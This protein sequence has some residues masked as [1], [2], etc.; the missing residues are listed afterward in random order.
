MVN[1]RLIN[2][3]RNQPG[4]AVLRE[5]SRAAAANQVGLYHCC[6]F[7]GN[8]EEGAMFSGPLCGICISC[9]QFAQGFY[10]IAARDNLNVEANFDKIFA[11]AARDYTLENVEPPK[12]TR[13][14]GRKERA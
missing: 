13:P 1:S 3:L 2:A 7:C 4:S 6:G 11:A 9:A 10:L 14:S 8:E 5:Q 12:M